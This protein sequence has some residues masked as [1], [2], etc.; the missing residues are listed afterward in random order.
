MSGNKKPAAAVVVVPDDEGARE[1]RAIVDFVPADRFL[2]GADDVHA[3][4]DRVQI[5]LR[6]LLNDPG[7][8]DLSEDE[9]LEAVLVREHIVPPRVGGPG[10]SHHWTTPPKRGIEKDIEVRINNILLDG[11]REDDS[12]LLFGVAPNQLAT[13][14]NLV[15]VRIAQRASRIAEPMLIEK[16]ELSVIYKPLSA[17]ART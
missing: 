9:R 3:V 5:T 13:G 14:A 12:W 11:A 17:K 1:L 15:G 6:L 16:L 4:S 7:A 2:P 8:A 10:P